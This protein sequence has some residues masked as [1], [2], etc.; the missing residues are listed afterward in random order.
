MKMH[1]TRTY[2]L[3]LVALLALPLLSCSDKGKVVNTPDQARGDDQAR[4]DLKSRPSVFAL[5]P[6]RDSS[7]VTVSEPV[8]AIDN[9][10]EPREP[11]FALAALYKATNGANWT[12]DTNWLNYDV[13]LG[14]WHGVE[15][16]PNGRIIGLDLSDNDLSG[17]IPA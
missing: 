15:T 1:R 5:P 14:K 13:P 17:S 10:D 11:A 16:D 9:K 6:K 12:K 7:S 4:V 3:S 2:R 8:A